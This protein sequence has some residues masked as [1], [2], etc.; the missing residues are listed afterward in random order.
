MIQ[1]QILISHVINHVFQFVQD[2]WISLLH[3]VCNKHEWI[4]GKCDHEDGDHNEALPWFDRRDDDFAQL[5]QI[6]LNPDL[7]ASLKYYTRFR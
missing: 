1:D 5:Q 4:G 7:L 6:I 2:K 3:H